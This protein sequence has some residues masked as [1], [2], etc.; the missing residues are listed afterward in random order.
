MKSIGRRVLSSVFALALAANNAAGVMAQDKGGDGK[1]VAV[2]SGPTF[3]DTIQ[4]SAPY[5]ANPAILAAEALN[6]GP[7]NGASQGGANPFHLFSH[8]P[9]SSL[10]LG[11]DEFCQPASPGRAVFSRHSLRNGSD[12]A[13]RK[14]HR[15]AFRGPN[16]PRQPGPHSQ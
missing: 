3:V 8:P 11:G 4:I 15:S 14:P 10:P 9:P 5:P 2:L 7:Y 13:G 6:S 16:L 1:K 12:L